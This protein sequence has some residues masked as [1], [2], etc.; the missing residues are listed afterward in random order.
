MIV[1]THSD[2]AAFAAVHAPD[3]RRVAAL[4]SLATVFQTWE[5]CAAWWRHRGGRGRRFLALEFQE[6]GF[7]VG[8]ALL[9][10]D[11]LTTNLRPIGDGD[12]DYADILAHPDHEEAVVRALLEWLCA[13]GKRF[14]LEMKQTPPD[15]V[16]RT[17]LGAAQAAVSGVQ[18]AQIGGEVC[19]VAAL[20]PTWEAYKSQFGKKRR[21]H[22]GYYER[23]LSKHFSDVSFAVAD[24][25]TLAEDTEAFFALH[26]RRWNARF[27][28][29][30]FAD[31]SNRRFHF[32]MAQSLLSG[33]FLRLHTLSL[34]G[35]VEAA[36]YCFHK[37]AT[38]YYYLGGFEPEFAR[39][40]VGSVLTARAIRYAIET[41]HATRFDFLR[42]N[43]SYKYAW[44]A[45]DVPNAFVVAGRRGAGVIIATIGARATLAAELRLKNVMHGAFGGAGALVKNAKKETKHG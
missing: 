36:L 7:A 19:P 42:G 14:R 30:A 40:S 2:F 33:G 8:F 25:Q 38:T 31:T 12:A 45:A 39:F 6:N 41:D 10:R 20:P 35:R 16:L 3:V 15:S 13:D 43:E 37:G 11:P 22:F 4:S 18:V 44:G 23:N 24:A 1:R 34:N 17:H 27:L 21:A 9:F 29:G 28:P 32:D 26:Q 5:W